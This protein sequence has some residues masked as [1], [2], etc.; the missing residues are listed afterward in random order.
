MVNAIHRELLEAL[1]EIGAYEPRVLSR[2]TGLSE[3]LVEQL[4]AELH[5]RGYIEPLT[6]ECTAGC[7]GCSLAGRCD[8]LRPPSGWAFTERGS[9]VVDRRSHSTVESGT[10]PR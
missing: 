3:V 9:A 7:A 1:A 2:R 8:G 4:I 5:Q 6:R 10:R